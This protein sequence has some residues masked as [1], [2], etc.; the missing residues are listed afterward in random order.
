MTIYS[1][2]N[3]ALKD[4]S[5]IDFDKYMVAFR[6]AGNETGIYADVALLLYKLVSS[7]Y[8]NSV[9]EFGSGMSTCVLA[10]AANDYGKEFH[11]ME[12][13]K[14][15]Y[16]ITRKC[17]SS[18]GIRAPN[19]VCTYNESK[20]FSL[21]ADPLDV[22]WVDGPILHNGPE[23]SIGRL[24]ACD[25]Y[26]KYLNDAVIIFDDAQ[27]IPNIQPWLRS[28]GRPAELDYWFNPTGR[29]DR[30]ILISFPTHNHPLEPLVEQCIL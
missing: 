4:I 29:K 26:S 27:A 12:H 5:G 23:N 16:D 1:K 14:K 25:W 6:E 10:K 15:W 7:K 20:N 13:Q 19:Y 11:A 3:V 8:V 21:I 2:Y 9:L 24:G 22:V 18:L 30:H 17:M 28:Y